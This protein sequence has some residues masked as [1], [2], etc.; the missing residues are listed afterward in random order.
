MMCSLIITQCIK[1]KDILQLLALSCHNISYFCVTD[2]DVL[3]SV[4]IVQ[5]RPGSRLELFAF[6]EKT[7]IYNFNV[8]AKRLAA[9]KL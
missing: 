3:I 1:T 9:R 8:Y 2:F 6:S 4:K 5:K 7:K